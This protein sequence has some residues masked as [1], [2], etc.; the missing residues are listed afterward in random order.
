TD[1]VLNVYV[2]AINNLFEFTALAY[3]LSSLSVFIKS[4]AKI[5]SEDSEKRRMLS[6]LLEHL[7]HDLTSW[8]EHIF[9]LQD[10]ADIHYIDSSFFSSCMQIEAIIDDKHVDA[11][12]DNEMEFF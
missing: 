9:I 8:R 7:G 2:R 1:A 4:S 10:T 11:D 6:L 12:D 5:I 3:A